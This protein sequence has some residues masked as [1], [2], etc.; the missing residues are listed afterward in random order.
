[1]VTM[2]IE[3]TAESDQAVCDHLGQ[4]V[5]MIDGSRKLNDA[6]YTTSDIYGSS[7][8]EV[9]RDDLDSSNAGSER[10]GRVTLG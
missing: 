10:R 4:I 1:M 9:T 7:M 3:I 5:D 2:K 6:G 8:V